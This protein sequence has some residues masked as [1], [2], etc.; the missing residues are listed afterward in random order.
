M[1]TRLPTHGEERGGGSLHHPGLR[2]VV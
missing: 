1:H 2:Q